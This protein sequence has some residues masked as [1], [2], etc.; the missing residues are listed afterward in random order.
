MEPTY[1]DALEALRQKITTDEHLTYFLDTPENR[2]AI[3]VVGHMF[4]KAEGKVRSDLH[5]HFETRAAADREDARA[6]ED[7]HSSSMAGGGK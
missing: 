7:F 6:E 2:M 3:L 4:D 1:Y 5:D